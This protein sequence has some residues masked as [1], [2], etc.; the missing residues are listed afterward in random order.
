M[1]IPSTPVPTPPSMVPLGAELN[2]ISIAAAKGLTTH[3]HSPRTTA[4]DPVLCMAIKCTPPTTSDAL[5]MANDSWQNHGTCTAASCASLL[6]DLPPRGIA[7]A[8]QAG[9][10]PCARPPPAEHTATIHPPTPAT[11]LQQEAPCRHIVDVAGSATPA[12]KRAAMHKPSSTIATLP[13]LPPRKR[14]KLGVSMPTSGQALQ[15]MGNRDAV[16]L[17]D[18]AGA[19]H[20]VVAGKTGIVDWRHPVGPHAESVPSICA[21]SVGQETRN[22]H[23]AALP[24]MACG[25]QEG[26]ATQG[27]YTT[28]VHF[29][30]QHKWMQAQAMRKQ[31]APHQAATGAAFLLPPPMHVA[32]TAPHTNGGASFMFNDMDGWLMSHAK[33]TLQVLG[34]CVD[35]ALQGSKGAHPQFRAGV[36]YALQVVA[37]AMT[38][39]VGVSNTE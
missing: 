9:T 1:V 32:G 28:S 10:L 6:P 7:A 35:Q 22:V 5:P 8:P 15:D 34:H 31:P 36:E 20:F 12:N 17:E 23:T 18:G 2:D 21:P 33:G 26:G 24:C 14:S 30:Q 4:T 13:N 25:P 19:Q 27:Q 29:Q 16:R 3:T 37:T 11:R 39:H 38:Q